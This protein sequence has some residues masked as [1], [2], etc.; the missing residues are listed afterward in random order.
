MGS[1]RLEF[2]VLTRLFLQVEIEVAVV[3]AGSLVV[4]GG[5]GHTQLFADRGHKVGS[6]IDG[7][8][9]ERLVQMFEGHLIVADGMIAGGQCTMGTGNLVDVTIVLEELQGLLSQFQVA[10]MVGQ[11]LLGLCLEIGIVVSQGDIQAARQT[12]HLLLIDVLLTAVSNDATSAH[13]VEVIQELSRIAAHLVRVDSHECVDGL[14]LEAYIIII[15]G[16]DD[17]KL[18]LG[19]A[20]ALLLAGVELVA[21]L[22]D[23]FH[24]GHGTLAEIV[25]VLVARTTLAKTHLLDVTHQE[26]QLIV[27]HLG[28]LVQIVLCGLIVHSDHLDKG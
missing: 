25:E 20:Q 18:R 12:I 10:G 7:G 3:V 21:F 26:F 2:A 28:N 15:G 8:I 19:I 17:A 22:V 13:V 6:L 14:A 27:G 11:R 23:T 16:I 24:T 1:A 5:I 9:G 4:Q